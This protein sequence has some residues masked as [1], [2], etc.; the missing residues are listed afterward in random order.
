MPRNSKID[1]WM[2]F[3]EID[4]AHEFEQNSIGT[5][6]FWLDEFSIILAHAP[7]ICHS[8]PKKTFAKKISRK[9]FVT[10]CTVLS[11]LWESSL[12]RTNV[13]YYAHIELFNQRCT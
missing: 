13:H 10:F 1:Y 2:S 3:P 11:F 4:P 7:K 8:S 5:N 6:K 9:I 12:R